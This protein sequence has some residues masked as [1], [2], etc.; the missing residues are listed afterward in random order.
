MAPGQKRTVRVI[1]AAEGK[2]LTVRALN[3]DASN[4]SW[5]P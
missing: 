4:V 5:R 2:Q 1:N 3:A